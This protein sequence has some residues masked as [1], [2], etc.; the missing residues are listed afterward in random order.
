MNKLTPRDLRRLN[1]RIEQTLEGLMDWSTFSVEGFRAALAAKVEGPITL[2]PFH[3]QNAALSGLTLGCS[4]PTGRKWLVFY[5]S[6][7]DA[8]HQLV[9]VLHELMHIAFGHCSATIPP[10]Q[11]RD[12]LTAVGLYPQPRDV[13]TVVVYTRLCL[14]GDKGIILVNREDTER[15]AELAAIWTVTRARRAGALPPLGDVRENN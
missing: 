10:E 14:Y 1:S 5:E 12:V 4:G 6:E 3:W 7:T 8:D 2:A 13:E 15:E 9:I 11:L